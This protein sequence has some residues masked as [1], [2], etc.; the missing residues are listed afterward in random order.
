MLHFYRENVGIVNFECAVA[1]VN[2]VRW[3]IHQLNRSCSRPSLGNVNG[4]A[5]HCGDESTA[6]SHRSRF[7]VDLSTL[8]F[9]AAVLA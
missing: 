4:S 1:P 2:I 7:N 5:V 8:P 3:E 9:N 6:V